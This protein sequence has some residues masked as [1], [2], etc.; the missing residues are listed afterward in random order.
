MDSHATPSPES[1]GQ[2]AP[3]ENRPVTLVD[4]RV[5]VSLQEVAH[6]LQCFGRLLTQGPRDDNE[7]VTG[8]AK[9]ALE[10]A[11]S[12]LVGIA[13]NHLTIYEERIAATAADKALSLAGMQGVTEG[14]VKA[15][16]RKINGSLAD[17][18]FHRT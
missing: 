12:R 6:A 14:V 1:Y 13:R 17:G 4:R 10:S 9:L 5:A 16:I 11:A 8:E 3:A 18:S 2:D 7:Q 15:V